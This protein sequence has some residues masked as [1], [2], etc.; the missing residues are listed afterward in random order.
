MVRTKTYKVKIPEHS[1]AGKQIKLAGQGEAGAATPGDLI[2]SLVYQNHPYYEIDNF[3]LYRELDVAPWEAVLGAKVPMET[4]D[5][6][7]RLTIP[8][9]AQNGLKLRLANR[10]LYRSD[11]SRGDLYASVNIEIPE[12]LNKKERELWEKLRDTSEFDP[13]E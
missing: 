5:G 2:L 9:G 8:A 13:R 11:G 3:D 6:N 4:L 12:T 1:F 7:V 10:G